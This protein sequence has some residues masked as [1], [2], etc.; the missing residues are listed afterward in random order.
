[1]T[2]VVAALHFSVGHGFFNQPFNRVLTTTTPGAAIVYTT[3]GSEPSI[4]GGVTNGVVYTAP[5]NIG[6]T[7]ALR[8]AAF[9]PDLLPSLVGSR[10][11]LFVEDIIR[12]PNAP[13]GYPT[14][15]V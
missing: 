15:N 5:I 7:T 9:A 4:R 13:A 6:K 2:G 11:Y 1:L 10:S 8:A 3:N 12:Q 14:G